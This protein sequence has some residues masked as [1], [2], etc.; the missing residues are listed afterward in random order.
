MKINSVLLSLVFMLLFSN[1]SHSQIINCSTKIDASISYFKEW[2][3][4]NLEEKTF[5][6]AFSGPAGSD[7]K[8]SGTIVE[9]IKD[10][11]EN[12]FVL[13]LLSDAGANFQVRINQKRRGRVLTTD[14]K[15]NALKLGPYKSCTGLTK[16]F[17]SFN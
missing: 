7:N 9:T 11:Q 8:V 17:F 13:N 3:I 5:T 1:T 15:T 6:A 2:M 14:E 10:K 16:D 4:I 12:E